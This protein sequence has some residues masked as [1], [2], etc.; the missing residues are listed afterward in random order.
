MDASIQYLEAEQ[1]VW[2]GLMVNQ[3][4]WMKFPI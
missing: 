4:S 2:G 3:S 1:S